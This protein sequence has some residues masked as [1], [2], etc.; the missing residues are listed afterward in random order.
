MAVRKIP[1]HLYQQFDADYSRDVPAEGF[2]GWVKKDLEISL[3]HTALIVMHAWDGKTYEQF[4]GWYRHV[5]YLSRAKT[6]LQKIFPRLLG[7]VRKTPLRII[8][9]VGGGDYYKKYPGY[10]QMKH[11]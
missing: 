7:T 2:N 8:N 5:E 4:P 9:I 10:N 11:I 3:E 6:I 1:A